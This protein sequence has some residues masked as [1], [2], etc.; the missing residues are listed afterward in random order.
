MEYRTIQSHSGS[1]QSQ[2]S[3][4]HAYA[5][6]AR[7][8]AAEL[9]SAR[10]YYSRDMDLSSSFSGYSNAGMRSPH[11]IGRSYV[12]RGV[13]TSYSRVLGYQLGETRSS[14][15]SG[16]TVLLGSESVRPIGVT[17]TRTYTDSDRSSTYASP[18]S[19]HYALRRSYSRDIFQGTEVNLSRSY[20]ERTN[21][22]NDFMISP[23]HQR[24]NYPRSAQAEREP[25]YSSSYGGKIGEYSE[26]SAASR[27]DFH[28]VVKPNPTDQP[29]HHSQLNVNDALA[30][31]SAKITK[32]IPEGDV[33]PAALSPKG[34][35]NPSMSP[36]PSPARVIHPV[37]TVHASSISDMTHG[38]HLDLPFK[39]TEDSFLDALSK[40]STR[41]ESRF[42]VSSKNFLLLAMTHHFPPLNVFFC[43]SVQSRHSSSL[44][45]SSSMVLS[46]SFAFPP[47]TPSTSHLITEDT[48]VD[49][50]SSNKRWVAA[51]KMQAYVRK[52]LCQGRTWDRALFDL[53]DLL[54]RR[55]Q[56]ST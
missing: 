11:D 53:E 40:S 56:L 29:Y 20:T 42:S 36:A 9:S 21:P 22:M 25:T 10:T 49:V 43:R 30:A 28:Q 41:S 54:A 24:Q 38:I 2:G 18:S 37:R 35:T 44:G 47:S 27:Y 17:S 26:Y 13:S 15:L 52:I 19:E 6:P 5:S 34:T 3:W 1:M 12:S 4:E 48:L 14:P 16:R 46:S 50:P 39:P 33:K 23:S 51:T 31:L 45:H 32:I 8:T 55:S 7:R